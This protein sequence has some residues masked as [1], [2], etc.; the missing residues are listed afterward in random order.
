MRLL[1]WFCSKYCLIPFF[2]TLILSCTLIQTSAQYSVIEHQV[3]EKETL[4]KIS[5]L[6]STKIDSIVAWNQ[7]SS[8]LIG[9][10]QILVIKDYYDLREE[11][12]EVNR[13]SYAIGYEEAKGIEQQKYFLA[14][15]DSI[16]EER[17]N[18]SESFTSTLQIFLDL[19][20]QRKFYEDSLEIAQER[21]LNKIEKLNTKLAETKELVLRKYKKKY[22]KQ[23]NMLKRQFVFDVELE[24]QEEVDPLEIIK[25]NEILAEEEAFAKQ[26]AE[27]EALELEKKE[28]AEKK[29]AEEL[30]K[31]YDLAAK[32][33]LKEADKEGEKLLKMAEEKLQRLKDQEKKDNAAAIDKLKKEIAEKQKEEEIAAQL[34]LEE[35]K[36]K[37]EAEAKQK[38]AL[39]ENMTAQEKELA[40]M[41]NAKKDALEKKKKLV[42][43]KQLKAEKRIEERGKSKAIKKIEEKEDD[44]L[45]FDVNFE[46]E[47]DANSKKYKKQQLALARELAEIEDN[48]E[49]MTTVKVDQVEIKSSKKSKKLKMGDDVDAVRMEKSRFFL[50]RAMFEIDKNNY[51][52]AV[53]YADKSITL[54]P[55]Y[56]EAYMLKADVYAS[57]GYYD[58]AYNSYKNAN[59][60]DNQ[61]PQLH[62][63]M[64]NCLIY[65]NKLEQAI[66]EMTEA[67]RIDSAYI[68]AYSG[69]SALYVGMKKYRSALTDYNTILTINKYFYP[70]L[71][72]RGLAHL[73]LGDY[74]EAVRDFN[75]LL[76]YETEDPSIYYHRGMAKMYQAEIYGACMDFLSASENG[77]IEASKAINKYCD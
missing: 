6:Y 47:K 15:I 35:K 40:A 59:L 42:E 26:I 41:K 77:F 1:K 76:E 49:D 71:K 38:K 75:E 10:G 66:E 43:E 9:Y 51:K 19:A 72:G 56:T 64:G 4:Y 17:A 21:V 57:F 69:R 3:A 16:D 24:L 70:A 25:Q 62:Y 55:N 14:K 63:N 65:L 39:E 28:K 23:G 58:K 22:D 34:K 48:M 36:K 12:L 18:V 2:L 53:E 33:Q 60:T 52:K 29:A 30:Q 74:N 68:L 61:I 44:V 20:R 27:K 11:E 54:N 45:I 46:S 73:N 37:V 32:K 50:S 5:M 67:I 13:L 7:L 31:Q 8:N